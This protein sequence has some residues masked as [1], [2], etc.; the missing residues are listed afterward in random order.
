MTMLYANYLKEQDADDEAAE[1]LRRTIEQTWNDG[2]VELYGR[3]EAADAAG[4]LTL[5]ESG[6]RISRKMRFCSWR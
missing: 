2:L 3:V 5:A 6:F 4:Q 1:L